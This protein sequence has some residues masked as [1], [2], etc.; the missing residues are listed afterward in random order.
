MER[1][2][3]SRV[4][5]TGIDIVEMERVRRIGAPD[6]F[7]EFFL[8]PAELDTYRVS[9]DPVG[10]I[11]SRFALK[12]AVI[13]AFPGLLKPHD[14]EIVKD[15]AKPVLR[16]LAGERAAKYR[17]TVSLAHSELFAAGCAV[18]MSRRSA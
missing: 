1:D 9:P 15:G 4:I 14:F 16:F 12:E 6:R 11:A 2:R 7:A 18:I 3:G 10:F 13:K 17:A 5:G 8:T